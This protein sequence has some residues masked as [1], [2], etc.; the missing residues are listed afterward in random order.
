MVIDDYNTVWKAAGTSDYLTADDYP[1]EMLLGE[2]DAAGVD[3]AAVTGLGQMID[4]DYIA[5][6][7]RV[8]P[9]RIIAFGQINPRP[10][11]AVD[12]LNALG[13][14][15]V[16]RG[17]K[18]HPTC[19]GY[20]FA[21]H[22]LLDPIFATC[23][24]LGIVVLVNA[25]DDPFCA[26]LSIEEIARGFPEVPVIIA[27]MGTAWNT[28]EAILVAERTENLY[29]DTSSA[30]LLSVREAYKTIGP[31]RLLMGTDWPGSD[32]EIERL[33]MAKAIS[34]PNHLRQVEGENF[35][36]LVGIS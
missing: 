22:G 25:L 12:Q 23:R 7:A 11:D 27:H 31:D 1:V 20:H 17:I 36:R 18:L 32:F 10:P 33:K 21:D 5:E 2:M 16:F 34:D 28:T 24:D 19:H 30:E 29:L 15:G 9:E 8:Y 6:C 4:N 26:P 3:M 13:D 14:A 35:A